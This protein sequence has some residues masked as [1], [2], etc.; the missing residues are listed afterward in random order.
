MEN[1]FSLK[2][3]TRNEVALILGVNVRTVD[4]LA[5]R[6]EL[7]KVAIGRRMQISG[8]SVERLIKNGKLK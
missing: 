6:G 4:R 5:D 3:L 7:E 2:L 8:E 1:I